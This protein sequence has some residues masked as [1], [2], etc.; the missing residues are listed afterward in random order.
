MLDHAELPAVAGE[1]RVEVGFDAP[2]GQGRVRY[3]TGNL[4]I[5]LGNR[6]GQSSF[7]SLV[8]G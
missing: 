7:L 5:D 8:E 2:V 4:R 1:G 3:H 6:V